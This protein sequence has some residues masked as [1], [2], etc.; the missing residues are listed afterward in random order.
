MT[1]RRVA[2]KPVSLEIDALAAENIHDPEVVLDI[3]KEM[4]VQVSYNQ[5]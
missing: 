3:L 4:E 1:N 2:C 5:K